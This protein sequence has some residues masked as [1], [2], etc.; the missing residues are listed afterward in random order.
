MAKKGVTKHTIV[1]HARTTPLSTN[2]LQSSNE[3]STERDGDLARQLALK[4]NALGLY[5]FVNPRAS[6]TN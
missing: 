5:G 6:V 1:W 2:I 3:G 4:S